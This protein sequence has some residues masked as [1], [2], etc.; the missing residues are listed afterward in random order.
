MMKVYGLVLLSCLLLAGG[1][2]AQEVSAGMFPSLPLD[3][4]AAP[5]VMTHAFAVSKGASA[6]WR[7]MEGVALDEKNNKLYLA[8]TSIAKGMSD[9]EGDI[10]LTENLCGAVYV[11]DLDAQNDIASLQPLVLGGTYTE[12]AENACDVAGI[13]SPDNL[14]VDA[15]GRVWIGEDSSDHLNNTLWVYDPASQQLKRFATVPVGAE[16]TG[17]KVLANGTVLLNMQ[18]PDP[19]SLYPYN[20]ATLGVVT[21]FNANTDDFTELAIPQGDTQKMLQVATGEYQILGRVGEVIPQAAD[22]SSFGDIQN[23]AGQTMFYCND[24]DGNMFLPGN[25]AGTEGYLYTNFECQPGGMSK[26]Y[27]RQDEMGQWNVLEGERV[28]FA[29]VHGTWSNCNASVSPWNTGLSGEEYPAEDL[30]GWTEEGGGEMMGE[31]LGRPANPYDY[32]YVLEIIPTEGVGTEVVK[33]YAM[34]RISIEMTQVMPDQKTAYYGDDGTDRVL[35]KF[36]ADEA[37]NLSAGTL[38]AGKITQ[39]GETLNISWLELGHGTDDDIKAA[40]RSID[41]QIAS[42]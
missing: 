24:P 16:V 35:Y 20:R 34:G 25:E 39:D 30:A 26:L 37:G 36:V 14:A 17:L 22:G 42:R 31:Y 33:H 4:L 1:V 18:H 40:I 3:N 9:T 11:A 6:E 21:G 28:S 23:V 15:K 32:G 5:F 41:G 7:K 10:Q 27:I 29:G 19:M 2:F 12:G 13:S 8:V 38:Y